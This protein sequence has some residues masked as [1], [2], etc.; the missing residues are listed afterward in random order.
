MARYTIQQCRLEMALSHQQRLMLGVNIDQP[1]SDRPQGRQLHRQVVHIGPTFTGRSDH[2]SNQTRLFVINIERLEQLFEMVS[3]Q[4]KLCLD[5]TV[6]L[7][8]AQH[9]ALYSIPENQPQG[10]Q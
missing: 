2:T 3:T 6:A 7:W 5:H 4:I 8:I 10:S 9:T 1:L